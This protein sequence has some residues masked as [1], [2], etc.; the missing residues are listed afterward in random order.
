MDT[1]QLKRLERNLTKSAKRAKQ[2]WVRGMV[3]FTESDQG[4]FPIELIPVLNPIQGKNTT[5][6]ELIEDVGHLNTANKELT[7]SY[8]QHLRE[9]ET[10]KLTQEELQLQNKLEMDALA[11]RINELEAFKID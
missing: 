8:E 6:A 10:Y 7:A 5:L 9:L 1:N 2:F 4:F 3:G 11:L